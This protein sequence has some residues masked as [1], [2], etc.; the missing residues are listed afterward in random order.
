MSPPVPTSSLIVEDWFNGLYAGLALL[1]IWILVFQ[2]TSRPKERIAFILVIIVQYVCSTIHS[3]LNWVYFAGAVDTNE[4]STGPGL[5]YSLTHIATWIEA[6][7]D[8]SFCLN[9]LIAD[10]IF[11]W[12]CW[13]VWGRK[14]YIVALPTMA[15]VAGIGLAA[16]LISDQVIAARSKEAFTAAKKSL[17]FVKLSTIYFSLSMATSLSTTFLIALRITSTQQRRMRTGHEDANLMMAQK[18]RN[19]LTETIIESAAIY[20]L[21]LMSF[22]ILLVKKSGNVYYAQNIFAQTAGLAPLIII[23]RMATGNARPVH[24][25]SD[26]SRNTFDSASVGSTGK[27]A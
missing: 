15:T 21:T 27:E 3:S 1:T 12:R 10:C 5:L 24:E 26:R 11:I 16:V 9:I 6:I 23:L 18:W 17:E 22:V 13:T 2:S 25:W 19:L 7:G 4:L 20:S 14:W 8:T